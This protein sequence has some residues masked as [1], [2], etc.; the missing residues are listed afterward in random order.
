M[1]RDLQ[2]PL[3]VGSFI[4]LDVNVRVTWLKTKPVNVTQ[5]SPSPEQQQDTGDTCSSTFAQ[6]QEELQMQLQRA[7]ALHKST[8]KRPIS[9]CQGEI[10]QCGSAKAA[11]TVNRSPGTT[12]H[13]TIKVLFEHPLWA[14]REGATSASDL[15][16][17]LFEK[18]LG[19]ACL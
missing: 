3:A 6:A 18:H 9:T 14:G 7:M 12:P 19:S 4:L 13:C 11:L 8:G 16:I 1:P 15:E 2:L 10:L 5:S 17:E